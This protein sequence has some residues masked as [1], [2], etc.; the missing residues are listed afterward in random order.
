VNDSQHSRLSKSRHS[1]KKMTCENGDVA[2]VNIIKNKG[3][4]IP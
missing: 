3:T 1:H 4:F 2:M